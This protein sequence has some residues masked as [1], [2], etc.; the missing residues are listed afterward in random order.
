MIYVVEAK[1]RGWQCEV[2]P[3][4]IMHPY[5]EKIYII[6]NKNKSSQLFVKFTKSIEVSGYRTSMIFKNFL[7]T[8]FQRL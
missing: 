5:P 8:T 2:S 4:H 3:G 6:K 7:F 1:A